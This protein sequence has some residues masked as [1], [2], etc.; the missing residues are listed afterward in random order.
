MS[1]ADEIKANQPAYLSQFSENSLTVLKKR[2]LRKGPNGEP[3]ETVV[4]SY[5]DAVYHIAKQ[6]FDESHNSLLYSIVETLKLAILLVAED[7]SAVITI[8]KMLVFIATLVI[9]VTITALVISIL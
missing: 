2:Y 6:K 5:H 9:M 3:D 7:S 8:A 1:D 4:E